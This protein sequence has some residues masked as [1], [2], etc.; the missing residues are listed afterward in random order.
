MD[1]HQIPNLL[2]VSSLLCH[3]SGIQKY[4]LF[5]ERDACP[6]R[7]TILVVFFFWGELMN[8]T[9]RIK[10]IIILCKKIKVNRHTSLRPPHIKGNMDM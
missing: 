8:Y 1:L 2:R 7:D 9:C 5:L 10:D 6:V 4:R 3:S